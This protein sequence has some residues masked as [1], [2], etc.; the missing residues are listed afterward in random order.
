LI[1][2]VGDGGV[3]RS[4]IR[5]GFD[6]E[7]DFLVELAE[8]AFGA[9][10]LD[11]FGAE[12]EVGFDGGVDGAWGGEDGL[13]AFAE[14]EAEVAEFDLF[15]GVAEGDGENLA[16]GGQGDHVIMEDEFD[17]DLLEDGGVERD[18]GEVDELEVPEGGEGAVG[19]FLGGVI[20]VDDDA[21]LREAEAVLASTN[22]FELSLGEFALF[23]EEVTDLAGGGIALGVRAHG[24]GT[25]TGVA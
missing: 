4:V 15:W 7:D 11:G 17:G 19:V 18:G 3:D 14:E 21:V 13:D 20:E 23:A 12:A 2:E 1:D 24:A 8:A 10:A 9:E 25:S 6:V 5:G 16:V 22:L